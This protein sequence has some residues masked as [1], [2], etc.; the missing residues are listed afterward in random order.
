SCDVRDRESVEQTIE[1]VWREGAL[2][3]VVNNAA[4]NFLARTEDLSRRAYEAVIGIVL[5]GTLN[6]PGLRAEMVERISTRHGPEYQRHLC[7][8]MVG[9]CG[10]I[11]YRQSW[12]GSPD[13]QPG[14]RVGRPGHSHEC[15]CTRADSDR[16]CPLTCTAAA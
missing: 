9:V 14:C 11:G 3:V 8:H 12:S 6:N 4:G 13:A 1:N 15:H 2:D 7:A 10:S 16:R 5:T